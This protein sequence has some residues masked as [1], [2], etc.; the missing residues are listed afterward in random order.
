MQVAAGQVGQPPAPTGQAYQ[1]SVRAVGRLTEASEFENIILKTG[2]DGTLVRL[3]DVGRAELGAEAY[4]S[5]LRYKGRDAS[6]FGISQLPT[7]N[8]LDVYSRA[9]AELNRLSQR[10]PPGLKYEVAFDNTTVVSESIREVLTTLAEAIGLVVLVIFLFLQGWRTTIIPAITIPVCLIGTFVFV[11][12]FGFSINTLTL[13]GITL[14]TGLVVDDAIVVIENIERH[15]H[16]FHKSAREAASSALGEVMGAVIATSL[17]LVTVFVPV[18]LFP[19]TTGRLYQQFALTIAVSVGISAW[20]ALT[21]TPA[22]SA[23]LLQEGAE[24]GRVLSRR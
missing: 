12:I 4:T 8:A 21:L 19:G 23:I 14:A 22:L 16:D 18:A 10:F 13:F 15:I 9:V 11:K 1:I 3:K 7:A 2:A 20:V 17:V 6:G 24:E 5:N